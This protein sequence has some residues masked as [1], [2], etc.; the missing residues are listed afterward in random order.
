MI[1][2]RHEKAAELLADIRL[3]VPEP[4]ILPNLPDDCRPDDLY[5]AYEVQRRLRKRL[6]DCGHGPEVG[7]RIG[8]TTRVMKEYLKI[9][10]PCAGTLYEASLHRG[11][12]ALQ[13]SDY[14]HL[15]LECEIAVFLA[16]DLPLKEEFYARDEVAR[17]VGG[18]MASI[19]LVE[20]RFED[21]SRVGTAS[22]IADDF[23][24]AGCVLGGPIAFSEC[25]DL[26]EIEGGFSVNGERPEK[27]GKGSEIQGHPLTAL[28][29]LADHAAR[30]GTPLR[31]G[32]FVTLG[33][34]VRTIYPEPGMQ[35][36]A[37]FPG[38]YPAIVDIV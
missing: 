22:L 15:G 30:L 5:A 6:T 14:H 20:H 32:H 10:H 25:G 19:E 17:A 23:F 4:R 28:A 7:W 34:V 11:Q 12:T 21:F 8:C 16:A 13:A 31:A 35:V 33:S 3:R 27:T 29:W 36:E 9:P 24:S 18:V 26:A 38:L 2:D 37:V 1:A